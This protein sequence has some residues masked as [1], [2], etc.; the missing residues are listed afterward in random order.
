MKQET[1]DNLDRTLEALRLRQAGFTYDEIA[2]RTGYA[3][4]SSA[5]RAVSSALK[6]TLKEPSDAVRMVELTR[7]DQMIKALWPTAEQGNLGAIDRVIKIME[8]R[9]RFLG[10]DS[11]QD[12]NVNFGKMSDAELRDY[13]QRCL[14]EISSSDNHS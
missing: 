3:N 4:R 8:R 9:A 10:L 5:F 7:L 1:L 2:I 14:A 11:A 12:I 6:K 13:I